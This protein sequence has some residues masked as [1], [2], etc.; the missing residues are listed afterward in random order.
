MKTVFRSRV[1]GDQPQVI[2]KG[3]S[4]RH[5]MRSR[6]FTIYTHDKKF[7]LLL[8]G[9]VGRTTV[10]IVHHDRPTDQGMVIGWITYELD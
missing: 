6:Y 8:S 5:V 4:I 1:V 3:N 7:D 2:I 10:K 9:E